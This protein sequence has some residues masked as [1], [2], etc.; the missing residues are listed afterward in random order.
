MNHFPQAQ[1]A[2]HLATDTLRYLTHLNAT[3]PL[4]RKL[5]VFYHQFLPSAI[6]A[7][8]LG[9]AHSPVHFAP[10]CRD[11]FYASLDLVR[12]LSAKSY[13]SKR[14]WRT[15]SSLSE[16]SLS[17]RDGSGPY[18]DVSRRG[19]R[20]PFPRDRLRSA[21]VR[22]TVE[23]PPAQSANGVQL[24]AEMRRVFEA[25]VSAGQ[26]GKVE[27]LPTLDAMGRYVEGSVYGYFTE[28]F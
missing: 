9:S 23:A 25:Y 16:R 17:L 1:T 21:P 26:G 20:S 6:A 5:Q 15:F 24:Q 8:F 10:T 22:G 27:M 13:V 19:A 7:A 28:M 12:D 2:V 14:L 11:D 3:T 4:Y 18:E